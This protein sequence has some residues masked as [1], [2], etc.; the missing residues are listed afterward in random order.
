MHCMEDEKESWSYEKAW[1]TLE[2]I[3]YCDGYE[4]REERK[5]KYIIYQDPDVSL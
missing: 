5:F 1:G 2:K 3:V 4:D